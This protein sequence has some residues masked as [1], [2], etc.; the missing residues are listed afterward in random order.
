MASWVGLFKSRITKQSFMQRYSPS[1]AAEAMRQAHRSIDDPRTEI[2]LCTDAMES[3]FRLQLLF[4]SEQAA[5]DLVTELN[6]RYVRHHK[7]EARWLMAINGALLEL[8]RYR[9]ARAAE[10]MRPFLITDS[11]SGLRLEATALLAYACAQIG[12]ATKAER[13]LDTLGD[14]MVVGSD[15]EKL[16]QAIRVDVSETPSAIQLQSLGFTDIDTHLRWRCALRT[17]GITAANLHEL[18]SAHQ[19]MCTK[20]GA[21]GWDDLARIHGASRLIDMA[22]HHLAEPMLRPLIENESVFRIHPMRDELLHCR[23]RMM[24][25]QGR[26]AQ[27]FQCLS[28]Y[29]EAHQERMRKNAFS[30]PKL[31]GESR[32]LG[33]YAEAIAARLPPKYRR[34]I[35]LVEQRI[36]DTKFGVQDMA[37]CINVTERAIQLTF[38]ERLGMSP[39]QLIRHIRQH[40]LS[41]DSTMVMEGDSLV[42]SGQRWGF[43]SESQVRGAVRSMASHL[44]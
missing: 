28:E 16:T 14:H 31:T 19:K 29:V 12:E 3:L 5:E 26:Y 27:A 39:A 22:A 13:L 34:I 18:F 32:S 43:G 21:R 7:R 38:K 25:H 35:S 6:R 36:S 30:L 9:P 2:D 20:T 10:L 41:E 4:G 24:A 15:E 11:P 37:A 33:S 17:P 42:P 23:A 1:S 40:G 8:H 44:S